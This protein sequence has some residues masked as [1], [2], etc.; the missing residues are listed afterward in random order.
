DFRKKHK[1]SQ[2]YSFCCKKPQ[3]SPNNGSK[4]NRLSN[5]G[6]YHKQVKP[7]RRSKQADFNKLDHQYT[8]PDNVDV[9]SNDKRSQNREGY[10]HQSDRVQKHTENDIED[11]HYDEKYP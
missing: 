4:R 11:G 1:K 3:G 8:E 2:Y 10:Q 5:S 9:K 7:D 6:T